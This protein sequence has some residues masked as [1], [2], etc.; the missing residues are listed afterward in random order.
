MVIRNNMSAMNANR[1]LGIVNTET[2]KSAEKLS[3]GY[4]IN[5]GADDAA[6]LSISEKM[7]KQ[8]RGLDRASANIEEGISFVQVADGALNEVH[9]MLQ[10]ANELA[11]QAANGTNSE[12]DRKY[13]NDEI[14]QLKSELER[15]FDTTTFNERKIWGGEK[16]RQREFLGAVMTQSVKVT[17]PYSQSNIVTNASYDKVACSGYDIHADDDGISLS[18]TGYNG[19]SYETDKIDWVTLKNKGYSFEISD[20]FKAADTDLFDAGGKPVFQYKASFNVLEEASTDD[21]IKALDGTRMSS[22]ASSNMNVNF[23][24]TSGATVSYPGVSAN[25]ASISYTA[26]YASRAN[27][28]T[29][30]GETGYDFDA[31]NDRFLEPGSVAGQ[32]GNLSHIPANNTADVATAEAC[33]EKWEFSFYMEG[34]GNVK[35]T[36]TSMSYYAPGDTQ[37]D[38][39]QYWWNWSYDYRGNRYKSYVRHSGSA[40]LGGVMDALTGAK[41]TGTPGLLTKANGGDCDYGGTIELYFSLTA[42]TAYQYGNGSSSKGVGGFYIDINVSNTDTTQT[43]LD[44][45]NAALNKNTILDLYKTTSKSHAYAYESTQKDS[46]ISIDNYRIGFF[47]ED[48]ELEIQSGASTEDKILVEYE[49]LNLDTIGLADTNVLTEEAATNAIDEIAAAIQLVSR[50]R[51]HFGAYQNRMEHSYNINENTE[52]NTQAAESKIRDTDMAEE[53]VQ[54]S[55]HQVL[56]Q[57]GQS[58]LAQANQITQGVVSLLG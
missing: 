16:E 52:E 31:A 35:A 18:W 36:S 32:S 4:R 37:E 50:E 38:D 34:I 8:I 51:S 2:Q 17:T 23:Q 49:N 46:K 20:Y 1:Q 33:K 58:M 5:R 11:V 54:Y 29:G 10:R 48:K 41:G 40:T 21:I 30:A 57:A 44:K 28:N 22:S 7:R 45:I 43:V 26:A 14:E 9:E 24:N 27:A 56:Q 19:T 3:S 39:Y 47:Y 42:D 13:I 15:V 25:S 55:N 53:M 6:G 12:T